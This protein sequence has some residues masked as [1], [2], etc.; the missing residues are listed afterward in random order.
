[1]F[2]SGNI[3][4]LPF[5]PFFMLSKLKDNISGKRTDQL[6]SEIKEIKSNQEKQ[7]KITLSLKED[8]TSAKSDMKSLIE[9]QQQLINENTN[10][11][12]TV[13]EL[14]EQLG[15]SIDSIKIISST[16]QNNLVRKTTDELNNLTQE[17]SSKL[18][19]SENLK[20]EV[21][22]TATSVK[23]ELNNLGDEIK[24]LQTVSSSIKA[25]DFELSKFSNQLQA[26][27][28]EKLK[29]MRQLD[30]LQRLVSSLRRRQH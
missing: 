21:E 30:S 11:L 15:E 7:S 25:E 29:L 12:R 13:K 4:K 3:F 19:G 2:A 24:K 26:A 23:N 9:K 20:K 6:N 27:D 16:I 14:K 1:M 22:D 28:N 17:I 5:Y 18:S 10:A 8:I